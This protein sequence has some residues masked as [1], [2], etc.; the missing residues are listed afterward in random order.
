VSWN[1]DQKQ[2]T[3]LTLNLWFTNSDRMESAI[4]EDITY[5]GP[6]A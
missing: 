6:F 3:E 1:A 4:F 5:P 2:S